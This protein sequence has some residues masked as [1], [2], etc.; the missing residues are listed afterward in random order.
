MLTFHSTMECRLPSLLL[1][2]LPTLTLAFP[3]L[4]SKLNP[5]ISFAIAPL[6]LP[7]ADI[8][9]F[10]LGKALN[11]C[12]GRE[13]QDPLNFYKG[14][15]ARISFYLPHHLPPLSLTSGILQIS[16][17]FFP[18]YNIISSKGRQHLFFLLFYWLDVLLLDPL[19]K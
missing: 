14:K 6:P 2:T 18:F 5:S 4:C 9:N 19:P 11:R 13:W 1:Q 16:S 7:L 17:F 12:G 10:Q 15:L 3:C 8:R